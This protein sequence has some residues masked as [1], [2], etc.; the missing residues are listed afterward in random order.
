MDASNLTTGRP[1]FT[2][3]KLVINKFTAVMPTPSTALSRLKRRARWVVNG[4]ETDTKITEFGSYWRIH[5]E[6]IE[7]KKVF[8]GRTF[9]DTAF[10]SPW[11]RFFIPSDAWKRLVTV[12]PKAAAPWRTPV[13]PTLQQISSEPERIT[14]PGEKDH[15]VWSDRPMGEGFFVPTDASLRIFHRFAVLDPTVPIIRRPPVQFMGIGRFDF[16]A[17]TAWAEVSVGNVKKPWQAGAGFFADRSK[18]WIPHDPRPLRR[19]R[20]AIQSSKSLRDKIMVKLGHRRPFTAAG[21]PVLADID[22]V[23]VGEP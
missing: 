11:K 21:K 3:A 13:G 20:E 19:V 7:G 8:S 2:S 14:V 9:W 15:K 18:F 5:R 6:G 12:Q 10:G 1:V 22:T 4:E 23:I 17:F 16:P